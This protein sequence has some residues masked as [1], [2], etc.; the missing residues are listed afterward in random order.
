MKNDIFSIL[1]LLA[2]G[3]LFYD[4]FLRKPKA[5]SG[6]STTPLTFDQ[7]VEAAIKADSF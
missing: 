7:E 6:T 1:L 4:R 3:F 5:T 2:V